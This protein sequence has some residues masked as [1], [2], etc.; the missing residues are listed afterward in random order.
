MSVAESFNVHQVLVFA[1]RLGLMSVAP[2]DYV[3]SNGMSLCRPPVCICHQNRLLMSLQ[4]PLEDL[5]SA[6]RLHLSV[7]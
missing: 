3:D 7:E 5:M 2:A 1:E 4:A 6:S